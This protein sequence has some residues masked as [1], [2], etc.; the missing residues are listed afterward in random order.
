MLPVRDRRQKVPVWP[1]YRHPDDPP[2]VGFHDPAPRYRLASRDGDET[3]MSGAAPWG[4][5]HR[6]G[7]RPVRAAGSRPVRAAGARP[8]RPKLAPCF[9]LA[10]ILVACK[11][12]NRRSSNN[13]QR[14]D[15]P[16]PPG[17]PVSREHALP[18]TA[19]RTRADPV[20]GAWYIGWF[21]R[22]W[23][24]RDGLTRAVGGGQG[25][26]VS[27][28]WH[29]RVD[30][31]PPEG[32]IGWKPSERDVAAMR[33]MFASGGQPTHTGAARA[34]RRGRC[35]SRAEAT[36]RPRRAACGRLSPGGRR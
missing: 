14:K 27:P 24:L 4:R 29:L 12:L 26:R 13:N 3:V 35:E 11:R 9:V 6:A 18:D 28:Q 5:V 34:Q 17:R 33:L 25:R 15:D 21:A 32:A 8:V 36:S 31:L 20:V 10:L 19:Q 7:S 23:S 2:R 30:S 22:L 1:D 16:P